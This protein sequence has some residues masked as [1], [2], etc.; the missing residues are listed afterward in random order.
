M[1]SALCPLRLPCHCPIWQLGAATGPAFCSLR[2]EGLVPTASGQ[3]AG[4]GV[5]GETVAGAGM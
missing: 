1:T 5:G 3:D 4:G 2:S